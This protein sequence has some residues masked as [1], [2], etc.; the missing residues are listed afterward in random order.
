MVAAIETG[1][2]NP[3]TN[4]KLNA[5]LVAASAFLSILPSR[6]SGIIGLNPSLKTATPLLARIAAIHPIRAI[7]T[8]PIDLPP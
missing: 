5:K 3:I 4:P 1:I 8:Y 2:P 6:Y 7:N